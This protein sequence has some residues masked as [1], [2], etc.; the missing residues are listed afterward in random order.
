MP[1]WVRL[2]LSII[3]TPPIIAITGFTIALV[4]NPLFR[5]IPLGWYRYKTQ[6]IPWAISSMITLILGVMFLYSK[7]H[8]WASGA[9]LIS[10]SCFCQ[11]IPFFGNFL[12]PFLE[13]YRNLQFLFWIA[14]ALYF[15][16]VMLY[17]Y[18]LSAIVVGIICSLIFVLYMVITVKFGKNV[19]KLLK[20]EKDGQENK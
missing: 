7:K 16:N 11:L 9:F 13:S 15:C 18:P 14:S 8:L 4:L 3:F 19:I 1:F 20:H 2:I 5:W 12:V 17:Q 10:S 6:Y